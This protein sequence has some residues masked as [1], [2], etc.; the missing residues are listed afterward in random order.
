MASL[1]VLPHP[2]GTVFPARPEDVLVLEL[3]EAWNKGTGEWIFLGSVYLK[4]QGLCSRGGCTTQMSLQGNLLED[5]SQW[6]APSGPTFPIFHESSMHSPEYSQE[7]H[8]SFPATPIKWLKPGST[9][10][11]LTANHCLWGVVPVAKI[12]PISPQ[13][14]L[15]IPTLCRPLPTMG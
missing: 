2:N 8:A 1:S 9:W 3:R 11:P 10:A 6:S 12:A 13:E 5:G 7:S 14:R 4:E 15:G